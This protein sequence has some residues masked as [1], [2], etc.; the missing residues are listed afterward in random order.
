MRVSA[1][2]DLDPVG[3]M[4]GSAAR[5]DQRDRVSLLSIPDKA[6]S[7]LKT[8]SGPDSSAMLTGTVPQVQ[9]PNS[10]FAKNEP[11]SGRPASL[12]GDRDDR[13]A[14]LLGTAVSVRRGNND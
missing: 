14:A 13:Q 10:I 4:A 12:E 5:T 11:N 7:L 9:S 3:L 1:L 2:P 6:L 8:W